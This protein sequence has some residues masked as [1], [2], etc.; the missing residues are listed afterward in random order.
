MG[1][2]PVP[3]VFFRH[4]WVQRW[5][6]TGPEA[7]MDRVPRTC[8]QSRGQNPGYIGKTSILLVYKSRS[9]RRR[10]KRRR[11]AVNR[12]VGESQ[13]DPGMYATAYYSLQEE[14]A[15]FRNRAEYGVASRGRIPRGVSSDHV[16]FRAFGDAFL[17]T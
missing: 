5:P 6:T 11:M 12:G 13:N 2:C 9:I 17:E 3:T 8:R 16:L 10:L 1:V 4:W 7:L 15:N 14:I